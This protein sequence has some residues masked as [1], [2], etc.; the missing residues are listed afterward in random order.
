MRLQEGRGPGQ[1]VWTPCNHRVLAGGRLRA[2]SEE[3]WQQKLRAEGMASALLPLRAVRMEEG[4]E[5]RS[6]GG[7]SGKGK[8][9]FSWR[10]RQENS[11]VK[12]PM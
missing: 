8:E 12:A 9:G 4:S 2:R 3:V 5:P 11:L 1:A 10:S 6:E 7:W